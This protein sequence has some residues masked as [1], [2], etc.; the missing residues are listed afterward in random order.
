MKFVLKKMPLEFS[1]LI[2]FD[3]KT[4]TRISQLRATNQNQVMRRDGGWVISAE[5]FQ[6]F[7][8]NKIWIRHEGVTQQPL[9]FALTKLCFFSGIFNIAFTKYATEE[10]T[11]VSVTTP[12]AM[13]TKV[14]L[15]PVEASPSHF[16]PHDDAPAPVKETEL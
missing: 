9:T 14:N 10:P 15:Q 4:K 7:Y 1:L 11:G 5:V 13:P 3:Q 6:R 16:S 2:V 8:Q 12:V